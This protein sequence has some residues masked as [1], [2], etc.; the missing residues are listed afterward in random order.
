VVDNEIANHSLFPDVELQ[1]EQPVVELPL[2]QP[3]KE[4]YIP[5]EEDVQGPA[6]VEELSVPVVIDEVPDNVAPVPQ[7]GAPKKS[8]A[9][10]VG[11]QKQLIQILNCICSFTF[12]H[13]Q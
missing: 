2:V 9:S 5:Q 8:Y 12:D 4:V 10:I 6:V 13:R 3:E 11:V 7:E 1:T